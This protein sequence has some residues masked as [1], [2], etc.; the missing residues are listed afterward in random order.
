MARVCWV[1]YYAACS[2]RS[3]YLV[4][5]IYYIKHVD[6]DQ[7]SQRHKHTARHVDLARRINRCQ[8]YRFSLRSLKPQCWLESGCMSG[9]ISPR[10][11]QNPLSGERRKT[12]SITHHALSPH[13]HIIICTSFISL[14][15]YNVFIVL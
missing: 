11:A 3:L 1:A 12:L 5:L 14:I 4:R 8:Q 6:R 2:E 9:G 15:D 13:P 7:C 10:H